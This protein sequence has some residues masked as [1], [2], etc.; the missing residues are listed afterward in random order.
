MSTFLLGIIPAAEYYCYIAGLGIPVP[1]ANVPVLAGP[2]C[3]VLL[4]KIY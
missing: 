2:V 3:G 1:V 4:S